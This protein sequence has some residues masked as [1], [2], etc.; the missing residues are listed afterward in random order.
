[1][2]SYFNDPH[3]K[4]N[5]HFAALCTVLP[6]TQ[7]LEDCSKK[8]EQHAPNLVWKHRLENIFDDVT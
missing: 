2:F 7:F 3:R 5:G 4:L 6:E 8:V 1:M